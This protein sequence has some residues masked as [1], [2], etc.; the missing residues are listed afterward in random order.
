MKLIQYSLNSQNIKYGNRI[1]CFSAAY[2]PCCL[3]TRDLR[4]QEMLAVAVAVLAGSRLLLGP[5]PLENPGRVDGNE[6]P[7]VLSA[8]LESGP[9]APRETELRVARD[10]IGRR[11]TIDST[12]LRLEVPNRPRL[13]VERALA[14]ELDPRRLSAGTGISVVRDETGRV[15]KNPLSEQDV[16]IIVDLLREIR[17]QQIYAAGDLSDPHGTHR[18]C[19][20]AIERALHGVAEEPWYATCEVWLYRGA[21]QEW[22]PHQID[23]AVPLSPQELRRKIEAIFKHESQKDKALFPGPD[24]REFWQRAEQ[25]NRETARIYDRLGLAEYEAIEAFVRWHG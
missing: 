6:Q 10:E 12:L 4:V 21:W 23:M 8:S 9:P 2:I 14:K 7:L 25:R 19:L 11:G 16:R 3:D 13:A 15:R 5:D 1:I 20:G 24:E 17:P 22:E 18:T